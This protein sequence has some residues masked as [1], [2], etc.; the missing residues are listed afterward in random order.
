[1]TMVSGFSSSST[2]EA[3]GR[4]ILILWASNGAVIMKMISSTS[5]TS[6]SGIMLISAIGVPCGLPPPGP[7]P[8]N[9]MRVSRPQ[10]AF[11]RRCSRW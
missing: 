1:M 5:M 8:L 7:S 11:C 9:A 2:V 10:A 4:S 6:T 3:W